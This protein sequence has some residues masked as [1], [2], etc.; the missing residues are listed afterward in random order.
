MGQ[1]SS[2][3]RQAGNQTFERSRRTRPGSA[4]AVAPGRAGNPVPAP[5]GTILLKHIQLLATLSDD[6]GDI[7]DA[8]IYIKR[9]VI[10][11]VGRTTDIPA[12]L[13]TAEAVLFMT[14]RV[15]I[16]GLVCCHH[17]MYQVTGSPHCCTHV[18]RPCSHKPVS[19]QGLTRLRG[20][21]ESLY[22]WWEACL[23]AWCELKVIS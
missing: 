7:V 2:T 22:G 5:S 15:V 12:E 17:H 4:S 13:R 23:P 16:P 19:L 18:Q 11:W 3:R 8:A 1:N 9:N 6:Y 21:N 20:T 14:N 10:H